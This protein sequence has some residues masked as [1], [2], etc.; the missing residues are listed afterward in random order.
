LHREDENREKYSYNIV[1]D[2]IDRFWC[3]AR[4]ETFRLFE[5]PSLKETE[6]LNGTVKYCSTEAIKILQLLCCLMKEKGKTHFV[7]SQKNC[8]TG[9]QLYK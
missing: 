2:G 8:R 5:A 7:P 6:Y 4:M 3:N 1:C 9:V